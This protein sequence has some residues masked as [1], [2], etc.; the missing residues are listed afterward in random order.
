VAPSTLRSS[1]LSARTARTAVAAALTATLAVPTTL[2]GMAPAMALDVTPIADIQGTGDASPLVGSTVT[3]QGV[4]TAAYPTGGFNGFYLQTAGTGGDT[5]AT[6]GA[7]DAVFVFSAAAAAGVAIGDHVEVTGVVSEYNGLTELTPASGGWTVLDTAATVQPTPTAWPADAA[8]REALEGMLLA[9]QGEF[10][11]TDN[12]DT[13]YYG[14]VG[15]AAGDSPLVQP[16]TVGRP[17][18]AE[19]DAQIADNAARAVL[20]DDGSTLNYNSTANKSKPLPYLTG[21]APLRVGAG[22]TFTTPV[23]LDYRFGAWGF[24][25]LKQLT[26]SVASTA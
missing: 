21:G 9:P 19:Y 26:P 15:L 24:Q 1:S 12:Y 20:L 13:N 14:T 4:V 11:V 17:L 5:D 7:S 16:T 10:T 3:T 23:V 18:S 2:A 22:V 25:P 8:G 6:P